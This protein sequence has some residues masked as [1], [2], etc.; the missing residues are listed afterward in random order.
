MLR[1]EAAMKSTNARISGCVSPRALSFLHGFRE[2]Q[3][4]AIEDAVG[5]ADITDLLF[6]EA[7]A[8]EA[9]RVHSVG[10]RGV[11]GDHDIRR[12]VALDDSAAGQEGVRADFHE[13]MDCGEAA[14]DDPVT[15]LN[16]AAERCAV[17]EHRLAADL[18]VVTDV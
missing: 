2:L 15:D 18:T 13:L 4:G 6:R 7:A 1:V 3:L 14:E 12:D 10:L 5:V 9:L 8:L 16:M 11:A 17:R